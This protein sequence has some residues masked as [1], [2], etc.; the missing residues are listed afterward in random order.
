M[1]A[2]QAETYRPLL[3]NDPPAFLDKVDT[4]WDHVPDLDEYNQGAYRRIVRALKNL[5]RVKDTGAVANSEGILILG[6]A[7]TGKTH[8]LMRV[9]AQ[10]L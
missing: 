6:E 3:D 9:A 10:P 4:P 1:H 7:G 5:V 8:L 2:D